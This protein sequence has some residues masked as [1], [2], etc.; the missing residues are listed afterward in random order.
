MIKKICLDWMSSFGVTSEREWIS[1]NNY[2]TC[3]INNASKVHEDIRLYQ[4][5]RIGFWQLN[6]C[7]QISLQ[8]PW[9]PFLEPQAQHCN[10]GKKKILRQKVAIMKECNRQQSTKEN[11]KYD[12]HHNQF[13][14]WIT[15]QLQPQLSF[16]SQSQSMVDLGLLQ[17]PIIQ[18]VQL[19][20]YPI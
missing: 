3:R 17:F 7:T 4:S 20:Q 18:Q 10:P 11:G 14:K 6:H 12:V 1:Q 9:W 8:L 15:S 16:G 19:Q 13:C 5:N 2:V